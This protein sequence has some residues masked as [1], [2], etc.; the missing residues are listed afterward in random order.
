M[1]EAKDDLG[2][3]AAGV[4]TPLARPVFRPIVSARNRPKKDTARGEVIGLNKHVKVFYVEALKAEALFV[5]IAV[6]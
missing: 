3:N 6:C 5:M 1:A 2:G 4:T